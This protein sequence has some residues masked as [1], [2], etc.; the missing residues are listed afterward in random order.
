MSS[1]S[2]RSGRISTEKRAR[3]EELI[4]LWTPNAQETGFAEIGRE[5]KSEVPHFSQGVAR[6]EPLSRAYFLAAVQ[7]GSA[8]ST[9]RFFALP[10]SVALSAI[11]LVLPN[12]LPVSRSAATPCCA[13]QVTIALARASESV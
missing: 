2:G 13:S 11:G 6:D 4:G 10:A 3:V 8:I 1:P 5:Q 12:P 9:R 7:F